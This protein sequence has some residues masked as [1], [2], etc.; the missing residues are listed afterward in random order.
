VGAMLA[1]AEAQVTRVSLIYALF[2][3]ADVITHA[4]Q[5]AALALWEYCEASVRYLFGDSLGDAQAD[6]LLAA[7][8]DVY[9]KG[10]S[11]KYVM[12]T[13]FHAHIRA[14]EVDRIVR[15]LGGRQLIRVEHQPRTEGHGRGREMFYATDCVLSVLSV[16]SSPDYV[17]MSNDAV[18]QWE[19]ST[20]G[21]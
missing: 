11:R 12:N 7:L 4:H 17:S 5:R 13:M 3:Q 9:P 16:L 8:R 10:L 21:D 2:D 19:L 15:L 6:A 20:Q 18:K 1:R 14:D